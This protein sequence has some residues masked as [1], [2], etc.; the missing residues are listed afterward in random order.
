MGGESKINVHI[1]NF[2]DKLKFLTDRNVK[3]KV[4]DSVVNSLPMNEIRK[5]LEISGKHLGIL[6]QQLHERVHSLDYLDN[7]LDSLLSDI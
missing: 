3:V 2:V 7:H 5:K 1:A 4:G 6:S